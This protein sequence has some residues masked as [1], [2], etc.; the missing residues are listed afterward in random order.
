MEL[1]EIK[2]HL[3]KYNPIAFLDR[4]LK[5][6]AYYYTH[7]QEDNSLIWFSIPIADM[8]DAE[9]SVKMDSKLLIRWIIQQQGNMSVPEPEQVG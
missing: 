5:G 4:I 7:M 2:K 1:N 6:N 8:G 9:F 3:Y